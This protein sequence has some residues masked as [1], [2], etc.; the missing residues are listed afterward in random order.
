MK[1]KFI[2][3]TSIAV[4][5]FVDQGD[6]PAALAWLRRLA[7]NSELFVAPDLMQFEMAGALAKR[8]PRRD[9]EWAGRCFDR[10]QRLGIPLLPTTRSLFHHA[11]S[12]ARQVPMGGYDAI[13]LAHAETLG[14]PWLTA[15]QKMLRRFQND[16]RVRAVS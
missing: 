2:L 4:Q 7:S 16:P 10:F 9:L 14:I 8:Q 5:W 11:M 15:D 12:L 3:D 6:G 1:A 13:Y